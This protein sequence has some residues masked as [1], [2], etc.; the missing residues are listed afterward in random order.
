MYPDNKTYWTMKQN[1]ALT[2]H[3]HDHQSLDT[4]WRDDRNTL[5]FNCNCAFRTD[6][7]KDDGMMMMMY[8]VMRCISTRF[9]KPCCHMNAFL[10][11]FYHVSDDVQWKKCEKIDLLYKN[12]H[13]V[14]VDVYWFALQM[15]MFIWLLFILCYLFN[16]LFIIIIIINYKA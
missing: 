12:L 15:V 6:T 8:A 5:H 16:Y 14:S 10:S 2:T 7:N 11:S 9:M 4:Q 1:D 13:H 3:P